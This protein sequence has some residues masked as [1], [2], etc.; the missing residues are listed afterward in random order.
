MFSGH[1]QMDRY[2]RLFIN[3][4]ID[5]NDRVLKHSAYDLLISSGII[6]KLILDSSCL[7]HLVNKKY[8]LR[9]NFPFNDQPVGNKHKLIMRGFLNGPTGS[10]DRFLST[11]CVR[12]EKE[13]YTT[14]EI[15]KAFA[16]KH[17]GI[18]SSDGASDKENL[19]V[20]MNLHQS[21]I[22]IMGAGIE[23]PGL[24]LLHQI[25]LSLLDSLKPL[26]LEIHPVVR[27]NAFDRIFFWT[28]SAKNKRKI[29]TLME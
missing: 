22:K 12:I 4:Y 6:R 8:R 27:L 26:F 9:L 11:E 23:N 17:G 20:N 21:G 28:E 10:L 16:N 29:I 7:V 25:G 3:T 15:I 14:K 1:S 5:L 13:V 24:F 2:E 18:H 19:I